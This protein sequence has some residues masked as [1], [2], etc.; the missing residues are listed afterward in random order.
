MELD[1]IKIVDVTWPHL[2][3]QFLKTSK[4]VKKKVHYFSHQDIFTI[5]L[6]LLHIIYF[7]K[8]KSETSKSF[9]SLVNVGKRLIIDKNLA[10]F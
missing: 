9:S 6:D 2:T 10:G 1:L 4:N 7:P 5:E 3:K 8:S